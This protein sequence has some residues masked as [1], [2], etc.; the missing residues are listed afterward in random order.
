MFYG[1]APFLDKA[2]KSPFFLLLLIFLMFLQ[3]KKA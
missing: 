2:C 3:L 1:V